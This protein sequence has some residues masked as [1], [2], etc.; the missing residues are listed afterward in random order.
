MGATYTSLPV[1]IPSIMKAIVSEVETNLIDEASLD[2]PRVSFK[3]ETWIKLMERLSKES[4]VATFDEAKYPLV[5]LLRNFD[6]K[7]KA[8]TDLVEVSLTLVI[9]TPSTPTKESEDRE[10]DNYTPILYPIYA[11]LMSVLAE[12]PYFLGYGISIEHTKTDNMHLGV[13][14]TQGNTKYLLPDCVDGIIISGLKLGVVPSRCVGFNYGPSVQLVYL[15]NISE[16]TLTAGDNYVGVRLNNVQYINTGLYP[17]P[18]Y[19]INV[20]TGLGT[21]TDYQILVDDEA[22][23]FSLNGLDDGNYQGYVY[24]D[25][26]LTTS[27]LYFTFYV[28]N[29]QAVKYTRH[30]KYRLTN[31]IVSGEEYTDYPLDIV[32]NFAYSSPDIQEIIIL[33]EGGNVQYNNQFVP[34]V[35]D[36]T[37]ITTTIL[38][39]KPNTSAQ[40]IYSITVDGQYLESQSYYKTTN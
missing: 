20:P 14:G 13:D 23:S 6:E 17:T 8:N 10:V 38:L 30:V 34:F 24:C 35:Q 15:N 25:D 7:Y 22:F 19:W 36:T 5:A 2:I 40:V 27:T 21:S 18:T 4:Q 3:C 32:H 12:S 33:S 1:S 26:G 39:E 29:N 16:I 37:T 28:K 9:V 31:F 11:E